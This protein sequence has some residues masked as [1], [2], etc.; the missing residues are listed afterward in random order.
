MCK[1]SFKVGVPN[2]DKTTIHDRGIH[3]I[4]YRCGNCVSINVLF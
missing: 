2:K 3:G 1:Y 4:V